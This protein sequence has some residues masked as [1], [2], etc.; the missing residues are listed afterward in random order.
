MIATDVL[1]VGPEGFGM[2][3]SAT[4]AGA[5]LAAVSATRLLPGRNA[6]R[7][8]HLIIAV[9]GLCIILFGLSSNFYLSF[10]ALFMAGICDGTSMVIRH[11]ILRLA[12]PD[13]LRGRIAAVKSVFVGSSNELGAFQSGMTASLIGA[14]PAMCVGGIITLIVVVTVALRAPSLWRLDLRHL[15]P[16]GATPPPSYAEPEPAPDSV[17]VPNS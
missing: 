5:L 2:L 14:G 1:R 11:A 12:S 6:G 17:P 16:V 10:A 3:R 13:E 8:L 4:A 9:F 15:S 7:V